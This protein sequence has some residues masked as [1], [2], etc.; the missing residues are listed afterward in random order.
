MPVVDFYCKELHDGISGLG[1][2]EDVLMEILCSLSNVEIETI[3]ARYEQMYKRKLEDDI[4]GDTSGHFK[5]LLVSL[6]NAG[7]DETGETDL[8][9]ARTDATELLR[10]GEL[11]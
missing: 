4:I 2:D 3:K 1:T 9:A 7:R 5:R 11:K 10:A 6:C 8:E